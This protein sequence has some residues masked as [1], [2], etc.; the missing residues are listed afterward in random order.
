MLLWVM[1][2]LLIVASPSTS[3]AV[4][5]GPA[6]AVEATSAF[7]RLSSTVLLRMTS[8]LKPRMTAAS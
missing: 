7:V 3:N 6:S 1:R 8:E 2:V 5:L 4:P